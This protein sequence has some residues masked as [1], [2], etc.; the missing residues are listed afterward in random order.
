MSLEGRKDRA[1][2]LRRAYAKNGYPGLLKAQINVWNDPK[3]AEDYDPYSVAQELQKK[4][5]LK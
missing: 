2:V 3:R 5:G 4:I 1:E